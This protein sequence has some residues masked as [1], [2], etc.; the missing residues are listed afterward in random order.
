MFFQ[1]L[2]LTHHRAVTMFFLIPFNLRSGAGPK[3]ARAAAWPPQSPTGSLVTS[4]TC[5][6]MIPAIVPGAG[7]S[8]VC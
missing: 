2:P 6:G 3:A 8:R 4:T 1:W 5:L 7:R